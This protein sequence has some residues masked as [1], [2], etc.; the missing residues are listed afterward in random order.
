M[1]AGP[2]KT[3]RYV[4]FFVVINKHSATMKPAMHCLHPILKHSGYCLRGKAFSMLVF[5]CIFLNDKIEVCYYKSPFDTGFQFSLDM[6]DAGS[7]IEDV[8]EALVTQISGM[9]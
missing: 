7:N 2:L 4:G 3:S 5:N 1:H 6:A 8:E 9:Y